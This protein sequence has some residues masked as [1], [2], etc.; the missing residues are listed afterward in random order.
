M[1]KHWLFFVWMAPFLAACTSNNP[2][3]KP[4]GMLALQYEK[5]IAVPYEN[6]LF[7]FEYNQLAHFKVPQN[8]AFSFYYP[9]LK[10]SVY[11]YYVPLKND[12]ETQVALLEQKVAEHQKMASNIRVYPYKN[13]SDR[14]WGILYEIEGVAASQAQFYLTDRKQHFIHGALYFRAKPN[15]DSILPAAAYVENDLRDFMESVRWK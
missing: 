15:Y 2:F 10:G 13:E 5:S 1:F 4:K 14:K 11:M 9:D 6:D 12:V 3:P 8:S 7:L